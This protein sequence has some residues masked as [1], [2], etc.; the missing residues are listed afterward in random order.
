MAAVISLQ[1]RNTCVWCVTCYI[2]FNSVDLFDKVSVNFW[3]KN[4][5]IYFLGA[6]F[7][8]H[9]REELKLKENFGTEL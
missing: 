7:I 8:K 4:S 5:L 6:I 2:N 9:L 3:E 1:T